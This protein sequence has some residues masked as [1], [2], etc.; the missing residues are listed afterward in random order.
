MACV[1]LVSFHLPFRIQLAHYL[2]LGQVPLTLSVTLALRYF[3]EL[4][5]TV[6]LAGAL[7][8]S[9]GSFGYLHHGL[10]C[11]RCFLCFGKYGQRTAV[12]CCPDKFCLAV[13][14]H[15]TMP[16]LPSTP[17]VSCP[18]QEELLE[19]GRPWHSLCLHTLLPAFEILPSFAQVLCIQPV[20]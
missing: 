19:L 7:G 1:P 13:W 16:S 18:P 12:A 9:Q 5:A 3:P 4:A 11:N 15:G 8:V 10:R 2:R 6:G 20:G 17:L 14:P